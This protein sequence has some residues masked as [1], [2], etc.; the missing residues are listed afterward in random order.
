[1]VEISMSRSGEGPGCASGS[2]YSTTFYMSRYY[3]V[4]I[5]GIV[6]WFRSS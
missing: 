1:M 4:T 3:P 2:D 5:L 6:D